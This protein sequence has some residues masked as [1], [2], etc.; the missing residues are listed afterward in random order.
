M[1][2]MH[3]TPGEECVEM[4]TTVPGGSGDESSLHQRAEQ[5]ERQ[6]DEYFGLLRQAQADFENAYQRNRRERDQEQKF[7]GEQLARDLL[8]AIDNLERALETANAAADA[9]PLAQGVA[10]AR[11]QLLDAFKR[12]GVVP[13]KAIGEVFDPNLHEAMMQ[14]PAADKPANTVLQVLERGYLF[15]ERVLRPAKVI[16]SSAGGR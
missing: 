10:L 3:P 8:P 4:P 5:A 16:I 14:H 15:H 2:E 12:H 6:R 11:D 13:M 7:R 1:P 9:N